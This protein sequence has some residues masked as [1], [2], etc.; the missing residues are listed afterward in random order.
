VAAI[1]LLALVFIDLLAHLVL[2]ALEV[3]LFLLRE[4]AA[5]FGLVLRFALLDLVLTIFQMRSLARAQFAVLDSVGD[6]VLLVLLT[7]V[8]VVFPIVPCLLAARSRV[9]RGRAC[10][11]SGGGRLRGLSRGLCGARGL[12]GRRARKYQT[13]HGYNGEKSGNSVCH[14]VFEP[15]F[16][17]FFRRWVK[18]E[19]AGLVSPHPTNRYLSIYQTVSPGSN[20]HPWSRLRLDVVCSQ[21]HVS[22]NHAG[23]LQC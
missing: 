5:M 3:L 19:A 9:L 16:Q 11:G 21:A 1:L 10:R 17:I 8:N 15:R 22:K 13:P 20:A 2:R 12:G 14:I 23:T 18:P 6:A 4:V 7:I